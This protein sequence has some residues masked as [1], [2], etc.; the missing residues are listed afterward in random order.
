MDLGIITT[1]KEQA[2]DVADIYVKN[3]IKA[4]WNFAPVDLDLPEDIIVETV[5]LSESL[6]TLSYFLKESREDS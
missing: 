6:F 5:R 3:G 2:Q 1:S 4:I